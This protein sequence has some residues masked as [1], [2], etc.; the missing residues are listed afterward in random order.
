MPRAVRRSCPPCPSSTT[1]A[2]RHGGCRRGRATTTATEAPGGTRGPSSPG[3]ERSCR[4]VP[5]A[6]SSTNRARTGREASGRSR[7]CRPRSVGSAPPSRRRCTNRARC[8]RCPTTGRAAVIDLNGAVPSV[9]L[10]P[11][12]SAS[13]R[14]R[15]DLTVL[16]NGEVLLVGGAPEN[17]K[18]DKAVHTAEIWNSET[19]GRGARP[20]RCRAS[21]VSLRPARADSG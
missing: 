20:S 1:P 8:S 19:P 4:S 9:T 14:F 7:T 2:P 11:S 10:V 15:G 12:P 3:A 21:G 17:Q 6:A 18:L 13:V 16:A 5:E